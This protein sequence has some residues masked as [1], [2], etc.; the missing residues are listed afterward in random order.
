MED[1]FWVAKIS[2]IFLGC[3][4]FLIFFGGEWQMLGPSLR[5]KKKWEYPPG[6]EEGHAP[7]QWNLATD[8]DKSAALAAQW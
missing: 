4:K 6:R 8:Q 7:C 3:L 5:M 2:N 1:I